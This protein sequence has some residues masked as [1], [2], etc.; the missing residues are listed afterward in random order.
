MG[1]SNLGS[2]LSIQTLLLLP[3]Y[4][5]HFSWGIIPFFPSFPFPR[6]K[7]PLNSY[8]TPLQTLYPI[9]IQFAAGKRTGVSG[10]APPN[11]SPKWI[12]SSVHPLYRTP[13]RFHLPYSFV[14]S[15]P[16]VYNFTSGLAFI[17][18]KVIVCRILT[19]FS[20][21]FATTFYRRA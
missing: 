12:H 13:D 21:P 9:L 3:F 17:R 5:L 4:P 8:K 15:F 10:P 20:Q 1:Q 14:L 2:L 7:P 19:R 6:L 16:L 18:Q 11:L